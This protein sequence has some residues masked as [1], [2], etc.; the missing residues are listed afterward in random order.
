MQFSSSECS[1]PAQCVC[2]SRSWLL[3]FENEG[4]REGGRAGN[5]I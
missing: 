3:L 4:G 1:E 5:G 2:L